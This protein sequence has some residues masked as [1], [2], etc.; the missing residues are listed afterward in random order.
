MPFPKPFF[1]LI[2]Q[3]RHSETG[4]KLRYLSCKE[5]VFAATTKDDVN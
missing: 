2:Q 4:N 3:E 5:A 1:R